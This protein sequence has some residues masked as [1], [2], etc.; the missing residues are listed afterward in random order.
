VKR[1]TVN[2][3]MKRNAGRVPRIEAN[4]YGGSMSERL[5]VV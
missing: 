5:Q 1:R 3:V 2:P 4:T